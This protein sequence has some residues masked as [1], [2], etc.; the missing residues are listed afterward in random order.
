M[1][2][3]L[4]QRVREE[5]GLCYSVYTYQ[6]FYMGRGVNGVYVG[7]RPATEERAVETIRE[8]LGKVA[9]EGLDPD[10]LERTKQQVKGQV[11]LSL[12]ATGARLHR[13]TA[14]ALHDQPFL[15]LDELL[16]SLDA[17]TAEEI[18]EVADR[19]FHPDRQLVLRLGPG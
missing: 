16:R 15:T 12:E 18:A 3:R 4:F 10:E 13:L 5:L 8:E 11:M 9:S 7:T 1:S 14:F 19:Y 2:S 6:S 17:I